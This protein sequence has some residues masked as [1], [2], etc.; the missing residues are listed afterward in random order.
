MNS[1]GFTGRIPQLRC[2]RG[3]RRFPG[4]TPPS[5][6]QIGSRRFA[7]TSTFESVEFTVSRSS[8]LAL[9]VAPAAELFEQPAGGGAGR[10]GC[11]VEGKECGLGRGRPD[12]L[13]VKANEAFLGQV[14]GDD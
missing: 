12:L 1:T 5:A 8:P 3:T 10:V 9:A 11:A 14:V 4:A 6:P 13:D 2:G 7:S